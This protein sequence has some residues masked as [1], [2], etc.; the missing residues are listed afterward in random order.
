MLMMLW[1]V[2]VVVGIPVGFCSVA[3]AVV[4]C[5]LLVGWLVV[6]CCCGLIQCCA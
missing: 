4:V 3:V 1:F 6:V 5:C 2:L